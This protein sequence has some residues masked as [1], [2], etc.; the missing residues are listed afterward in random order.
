MEAVTPLLWDRAASPPLM[1]TAT[2]V[3]ITH[4]KNNP[5]RMRLSG[6]VSDRKQCGKGTTGGINLITQV[7]V[8]EG[9]AN[10]ALR[11]AHHFQRDIQVLRICAL[12][13]FQHGK[14]GL[15]HERCEASE[16]LVMEGWL[17]EPSLRPW[18]QDQRHVPIF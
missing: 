5:S 16:T 6:L 1:S 2:L 11:Q 15:G 7:K 4:S 18:S 14:R 8:E 17:H 9:K 12:P 10:N 13:A 3:A